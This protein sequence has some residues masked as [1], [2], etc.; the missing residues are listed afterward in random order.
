VLRRVVISFS[1]VPCAE[2]DSAFDSL[3]FRCRGP[4]QPDRLMGMFRGRLGLL[5]YLPLFHLVTEPLCF[6]PQHPLP[7]FGSI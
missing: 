1:S 6:L 2:F 5:V 4:C 3:H 7:F